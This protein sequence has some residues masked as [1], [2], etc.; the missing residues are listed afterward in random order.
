MKHLKMC[1]LHFLPW[2]YIALLPH[3]RTGLGRQFILPRKHVQRQKALSLQMFP[4]IQLAWIW[5]YYTT[6]FFDFFSMNV[7]GNMYCEICPGPLWLSC[8]LEQTQQCFLRKTDPQLSLTQT[9]SDFPFMHVLVKFLNF[10]CGLY[11]TMVLLQLVILPEI[12]ALNTV[13]Q[14][15]FKSYLKEII[16]M[17]DYLK[18]WILSY[19]FW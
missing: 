19:F 16:F 8:V 2:W 18:N 13:F 7:E 15:F 17:V 11:H 4:Q 5:Q 10:I 1:I 14:C 6:D 9:C 12:I 3:P